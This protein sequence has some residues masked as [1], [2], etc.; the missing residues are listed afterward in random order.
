MGGGISSSST[1]RASPEPASSDGGRQPFGGTGGWNGFSPA[2][3]GHRGRGAK[4]KPPFAAPGMPG[5]GLPPPSRGKRFMPLFRLLFRS[6]R[7]HLYRFR[8]EVC[9]PALRGRPPDGPPA[10]EKQKEPLYFNRL[11]KK[12]ARHGIC[13]IPVGICFVTPYQRSFQEIRHEL[14]RKLGYRRR[15]DRRP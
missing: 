1:P 5:A 8:Y 7:E 12:A 15:A 14:C 6:F 10:W 2:G 13:F 3:K 9:G 4:G 11:C